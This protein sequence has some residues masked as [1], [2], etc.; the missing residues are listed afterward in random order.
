MGS[1]AASPAAAELKMDEAGHFCR[2]R[3]QARRGGGRNDLLI[4]D[5]GFDAPSNQIAAGQ[6]FPLFKG[7]SQ[8][9]FAVDIIA[10]ASGEDLGRCHLTYQVPE[11]R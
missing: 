11:P 2:R 7:T 3:Q 9:T 8:G 6:K 4:L 5:L 10:E 1:P